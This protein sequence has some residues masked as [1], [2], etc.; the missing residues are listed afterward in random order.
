MTVVDKRL[1]EW[2]S[3]PYEYDNFLVF[4]AT[5]SMS[6][7]YMVREG[8]AEAPEYAVLAILCVLRSEKQKWERSPR[9][10]P[11]QLNW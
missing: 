8:H 5:T 6:A 2:S 3:M 11:S 9:E 1:C 4:F 10:P 7:V